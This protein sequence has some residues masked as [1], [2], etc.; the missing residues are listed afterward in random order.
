MK[1]TLSAKDVASTDGP[2]I[3]TRLRLLESVIHALERTVKSARGIRDRLKSSSKAHGT[4]K[5]YGIS[6]LDLLQKGALFTDD[7]LELQWL[8]GGPVLKGK[9]KADGTVMVKTRDGWQS[10]SSL[11]T[12]VSHVAGR[13]LNGWKHWR[14][15]NLDGTATALEAIRDR[16]LKEEVNG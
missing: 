16:Y 8:K 2:E 15:V 10:F 3:D 5:H 4:K 14:R 13:S 9:V 11:S 7:R 1:L 12:A 6:L